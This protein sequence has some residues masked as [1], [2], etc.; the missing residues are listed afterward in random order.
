MPRAA[1]NV[2]VARMEAKLYLA[3]AEEFLQEARAA[4][5]A[6]RHDAAMLNAIHAAISAGDA[7]TIVLAGRRSADADHQRAVDLLEEVAGSSAEIKGK[8]R[9]VRAL[10][11]KKNIV[12]YESRRATAGEAGNAVDRAGRIVGWATETVRRARM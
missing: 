9:Q 4:A 10:L 5:Q 8:A 1:K 6:S 7:V 3:K 2:P 12:Q 11:A